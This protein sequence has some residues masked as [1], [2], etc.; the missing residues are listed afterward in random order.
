MQWLTLLLTCAAILVLPA[1]A[2][3]TAFDRPKPRR[4][5]RQ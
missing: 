5:P 2:L 3:V 1:A 4:K